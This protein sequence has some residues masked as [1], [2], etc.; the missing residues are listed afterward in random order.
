MAGIKVPVDGTRIVMIA[1]GKVHKVPVW[2]PIQK[3]MIKD[4]HAR[5]TDTGWPLWSVDVVPDDG[6][7]NA[8]SEAVGVRVPVTS[9]GPPV[10][11][12][13]QP[14][15][16]E[17]LEVAVRNSRTGGFMAYWSAR[18]IVS[19]QAARRGGGD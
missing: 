2:D 5:D 1:T 16:F 11:A 18:G 15:Q 10:V 3:V 13:W 19:A 9:D 4:S 8:R 14:V 6:D 17:G 7:E 12:K